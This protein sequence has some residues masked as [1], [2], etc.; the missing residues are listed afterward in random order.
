MFFIGG[1]FGRED[2]TWNEKHD[3]IA[4]AAEL[5]HMYRELMRIGHPSDYYST[6]VT[7]SHD[8]KPVEKGIPRWFE[9][10]PEDHWA[11]VTSGEAMVGFFK[12]EDGTDAL[13]VANHKIWMQLLPHRQ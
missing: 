8:N 2:H 3:L 7:R 6:P 12:Y 13:Y 9:P 4:T 11:R 5:R 10:F 1:P